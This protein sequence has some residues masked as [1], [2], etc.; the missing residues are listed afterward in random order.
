[1][2]YCTMAGIRLASPGVYPSICGILCINSMVS[3]PNRKTHPQKPCCKLAKDKAQHGST[4]SCGPLHRST[5][6]YQLAILTSSSTTSSEGKKVQIDGRFLA[7]RQPVA[8]DVFPT[9]M[10]LFEGLLLSIQHH[11]SVWYNI[12]S[13]HWSQSEWLMNLVHKSQPTHTE[14][15]VNV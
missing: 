13:H 11:W 5:K 4:E 8:V 1:M 10:S 9:L 12:F 7:K 2:D 15:D 6:H 14:V 3:Q